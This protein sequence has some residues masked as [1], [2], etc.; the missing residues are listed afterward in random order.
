MTQDLILFF[1]FQVF[2]IT[3]NDKEQGPYILYV[4]M[5]FYISGKKLKQCIH[6]PQYNVQ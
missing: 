3:H 1:T 6:S 5:Y 4:H 2:I